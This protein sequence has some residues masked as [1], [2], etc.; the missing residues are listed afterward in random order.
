MWLG[1][2]GREEGGRERGGQREGGRRERVSGVDRNAITNGIRTVS[3]EL[4]GS[5]CVVEPV[6][7]VTDEGS[8]MGGGREV[9]V[10]RAW[11]VEVW[12]ESVRVDG[13]LWREQTAIS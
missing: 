10:E 9:V 7:R 2:G 8:S 3:C 11:R 6:V 1:G 12:E 5:M 4:G 13:S